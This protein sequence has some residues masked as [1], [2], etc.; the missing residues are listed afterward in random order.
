M[1]KAY[2]H[3]IPPEQLTPRQRKDKKYREANR[4]KRSAYQKEYYKRK[5]EQKEPK[6]IVKL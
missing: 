6:C 5:K 4:E 3:T 1:V 2:I